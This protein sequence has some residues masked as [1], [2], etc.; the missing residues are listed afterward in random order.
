MLS[1]PPDSSNPSFLFLRVLLISSIQS[2]TPEQV[3]HLARWPHIPASV[4]C[5]S[6]CFQK[7]VCAELVG[8]DRE[9]CTHPLIVTPK[10]EGRAERMEKSGTLG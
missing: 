6:I 9:E 2:H 1:F 4:P 3:K 7:F 8:S 10:A 5:A